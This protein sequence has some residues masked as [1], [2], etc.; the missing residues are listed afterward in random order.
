[1]RSSSARQTE[2]REQRETLFIYAICRHCRKLTALMISIARVIH[3]RWARQDNAIDSREKYGDI[4]LATSPKFG[5]AILSLL[6][7]Q[8]EGKCRRCCIT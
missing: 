5:T 3:H 7:K 6:R 8:V 4:A 1:M 2:T